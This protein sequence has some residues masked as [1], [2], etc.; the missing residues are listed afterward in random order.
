MQYRKRKFATKVKVQHKAVDV[1]YE[2]MMFYH[3]KAYDIYASIKNVLMQSPDA[4]LLV[5]LNRDM[6]KFNTLAIE[7]A[8][9]LAPYQSQR[10]E[11]LEIRQNVTHRY[12]I[13]AP[14]PDMDPSQWLQAAGVNSD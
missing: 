12:V 4:G 5:A 6:H 11:A 13:K 3:G 14:M 8:T 9:K 1:L 10:L 7:C 2:K